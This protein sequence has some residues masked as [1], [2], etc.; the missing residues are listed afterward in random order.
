M[1]DEIAEKVQTLG[2]IAYVL[3]IE[4]SVAKAAIYARA[5]TGLKIGIAGEEVGG[6]IDMSLRTTDEGVDLNRILRQV[7][8]ALG[9]TGGGHPKAA[10]ATIPADNFQRFLKAIDEST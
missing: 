10:G 7:A 5:E 1:R 4:G 6:C 3:N 8:P 9:G 2:K